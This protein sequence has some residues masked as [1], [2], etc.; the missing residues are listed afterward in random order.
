MIFETQF[1]AK[2]KKKMMDFG[3]KSSE[4]KTTFNERERIGMPNERKRKNSDKTHES[5]LPDFT[6]RLAG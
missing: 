3:V 4:E 5:G 2:K 1:D 6:N